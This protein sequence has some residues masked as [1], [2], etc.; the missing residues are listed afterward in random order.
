MTVCCCCL[1]FHQDTN[2]VEYKDLPLR[3]G[4]EIPKNAVNWLLDVLTVDNLLII[5][6]NYATK[7]RRSITVNNTWHFL[8]RCF[9]LKAFKWLK[10]QNPS[11]TLQAFISKHLQEVLSLWRVL[12]E[13]LSLITYLLHCTRIQNI[14][15]FHRNISLWGVLLSLPGTEKVNLLLTVELQLI[16]LSWP[17]CMFKA[18]KPTQRGSF[19]K[20]TLLPLSCGHAPAHK[21]I[22]APGPSVEKPGPWCSEAG[23]AGNVSRK[24]SLINTLQEES[25]SNR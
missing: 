10:G 19:G 7:K 13:K 1:F 11:C 14:P 9:T 24:N 16:N 18:L 25:Q 15:H 12:K 3:K 2:K 22:L 17:L 20:K 21:P 5:K 4:M 23:K 6:Q 8:C